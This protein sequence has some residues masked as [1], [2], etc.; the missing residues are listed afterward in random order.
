VSKWKW[1]FVIGCQ[2]KSPVPTVTEFWNL[3]KHGIT[4]YSVT[5]KCT[6]LKY[7]TVFNKIDA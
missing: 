7:F 6:N 1:V 3:C 2:F 4:V 5:N